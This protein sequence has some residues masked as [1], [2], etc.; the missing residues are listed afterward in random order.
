MKAYVPTG[1]HRGRLR[2]NIGFDVDI[3]LDLSTF[4]RD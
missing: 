3:D 2:A 4:I 1:I